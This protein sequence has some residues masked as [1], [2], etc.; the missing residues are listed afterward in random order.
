MSL[1]NEYGW[2]L[3]FEYYFLSFLEN[4]EFEAVRSRSKLMWFEEALCSIDFVISVIKVLK[5]FLYRKSESVLQFE[6]WMNLPGFYRMI[7]DG[8]Y[9]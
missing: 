9:P 6:I 2:N 1:S 5:I 7:K 3:S 8:V 4:V